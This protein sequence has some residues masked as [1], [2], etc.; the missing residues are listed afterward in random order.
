MTGYLEPGCFVVNSAILRI[1][2][3]SSHFVG[4][5][6]QSY[7]M[8]SSLKHLVVHNPTVHKLKELGHSR[9]NGEDEHITAALLTLKLANG[10]R[11]ILESNINTTIH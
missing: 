9:L 6:L 2:V 1:I 4:S 10:L 3:V 11:L 5:L 7:A 8:T